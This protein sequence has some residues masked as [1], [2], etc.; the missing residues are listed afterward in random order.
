[1]IILHI[2]N[3]WGQVSE[4]PFGGDYA[5]AIAMQARVEGNKD[6]VSTKITGALSV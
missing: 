3:R 5:G 4:I 6:V 2:T 1:M